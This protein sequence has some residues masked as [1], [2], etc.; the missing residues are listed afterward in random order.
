[1]RRCRPSIQ[2]EGEVILQVMLPLTFTAVPDPEECACPSSKESTADPDDHNLFVSKEGV[3]LRV[4]VPTDESGREGP[5][6][7]LLEMLD[8]LHQPV[9]ASALP[10]PAER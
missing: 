5:D 7:E 3:K 8:G 9:P 1:M 10:T 4:L 2:N 6:E